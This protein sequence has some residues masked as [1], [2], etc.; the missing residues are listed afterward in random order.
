MEESGRVLGG[1]VTVSQVWDRYASPSKPVKS[2]LIS[3]KDID[4]Q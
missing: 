2:F 3:A 4:A 1:E